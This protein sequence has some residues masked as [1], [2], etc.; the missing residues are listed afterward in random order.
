VRY[1]QL[2][3]VLPSPN[4][5]TC[6]VD[7]HPSQVPSQPVPNR[8]FKGENNLGDSSGFLFALYSKLTQEEDTKMAERWQK[9]AEGII[10]FVR[11]EVTS[12]PADC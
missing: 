4:S 6:I 2:A 5:P 3:L 1:P 12:H 11:Y 7:G 9:D 8:P 10:I